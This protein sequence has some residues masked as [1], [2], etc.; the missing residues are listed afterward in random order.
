MQHKIAEDNWY[1]PL[2]VD[3]LNVEQIL[4]IVHVTFTNWLSLVLVNDL[5]IASIHVGHVDCVAICPIHFP[6]R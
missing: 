3:V 2:N 6:G 1:W 4:R 5:A